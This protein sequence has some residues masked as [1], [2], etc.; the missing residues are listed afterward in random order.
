M[1]AEAAILRRHLSKRSKKPRF[2]LRIQ[3]E[4]QKCKAQ[5]DSV[6]SRAR[7]HR[8][9]GPMWWTK[10]QN[11]KISNKKQS[12]EKVADKSSSNSEDWDENVAN[13][14]AP[15]MYHL[16]RYPTRIC[17][18]RRHCTRA[19]PLNPDGATGC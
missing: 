5:L 10:S 16:K 3:N 18:L 15:K 2:T 14:I 9:D 4:L 11:E 1:G 19:R 17:R 13:K 12:T 8:P 7:T 6:V